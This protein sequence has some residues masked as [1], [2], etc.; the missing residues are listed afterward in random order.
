LNK[1][2]IFNVVNCQGLHSENF[3]EA[4]DRFTYFRFPLGD[5]SSSPFDLK[6][7]EGMVRYFNTVF[8][9]IDQVMEKGGNVLIHCL[10]GAHRAGTTACAW[11]I[12]ASNLAASEAIKLAKSRRSAIDPI[13]DF[14][15]MLNILAS[16]L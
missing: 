14:T 9:F 3:H 1:F 5:S 15:D 10:A 12:Y 7:K 2:E 6:T 8:T 13:C 11:I 16:G 4:D